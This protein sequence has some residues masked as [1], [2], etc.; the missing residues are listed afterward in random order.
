M[1]GIVG[2]GFGLYGYLPALC[3]YYP[4]Q[5]IMMEKRHKEKF[6]NRI[7][8]LKYKDRIEWVEGDRS[9]VFFSSL[10]VLAIPPTEVEKYL[11]PILSSPW[12]KKI[13]VDKPICQDPYTTEAFIKVVESKEI[14]ICSSYILLYSDWIKDLA[15]GKIKDIEWNILNNNP[16]NSWKWNHKLGGG[17]LRFYGIHLLSL[18]SHLG[19][20]LKNISIRNK[21]E[22][23]AQFGEV[24]VYINSDAFFP[25]FD[26]TKEK[27]SRS[28]YHPFKTI[29]SGE[30]RR[31]PYLIKLIDDFEN[32]YDKVNRLMK[33]TNK[34]W[35]E[36][37]QK[38]N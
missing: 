5:K 20:E 16:K 3:Q 37:E 7:E 36:A 13:I 35:M 11:L 29:S 33:N 2:G 4:D 14:K 28:D 9:I 25:S 24:T 32:N 27:N 23:T 34:L 12:I 38:L 15:N 31:V 17:V 6:N 30:D 1:I 18:F 22:L 26:L 8:L 21:T 19:Y 10:L